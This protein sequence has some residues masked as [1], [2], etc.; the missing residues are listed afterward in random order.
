M[1]KS[2]LKKVLKN[3]ENFDEERMIVKKSI[4]NCGIIWH[5]K[6]SAEQIL[7]LILSG[8]IS[9]LY[10]DIGFDR[11]SINKTYLDNLHKT[12]L[13]NY[14]NVDSSTVIFRSDKYKGRSLRWMRYQN[15]DFSDRGCENLINF[16]FHIFKKSIESLIYFKFIYQKL[17]KWL[18]NV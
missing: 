17:K 12:I 18:N 8:N 9:Q 15:L 3:I 5:T 6:F 14:I 16:P 4:I 13:Q 10:C 2:Y 1:E 7:T 11:T